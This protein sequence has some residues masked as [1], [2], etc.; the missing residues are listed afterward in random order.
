MAKI[1]DPD[2]LSIAVTEDGGTNYATATQTTGSLPAGIEVVLDMVAKTVQLQVQGNLDDT[3]PGRTS[4]VTGRALYS[5]LKEEWLNGTNVNTI[6]RRYRFPI[7]VIFEG[8]FIWIN[9]WEPADNQTR[10]LIR[11]AGFQESTT[12]N[13]YATFIS[14]GSTDDPLVDLAYYI[15]TQSPTASTTDFDKTGELNE[16]V[17]ITGN[18][19]YFKAFLREQGKTYAEYD[20]LTEQGLSAITFQAY[21]FPLQNGNDLK[22]FQ[23]DVFIDGNAPYT[24]MSIDYCRVSGSRPG[25]SPRSTP[26]TRSSRTRTAG[27]SSRRRAALPPGTTP[28]SGAALTPASPGSR[29]TARS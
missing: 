16:P 14:L 9:G 24:G 5:F 12:G 23:S 22:V 21:S 2:Q 7:Q 8:S 29:T 25:R 1:V 28:T 11:D 10:D 18:T 19:T 20:L 4:G 15:Q 6:L 27:G 3:A 17:D 26:P 13:I